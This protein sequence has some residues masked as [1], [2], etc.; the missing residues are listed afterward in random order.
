MNQWNSIPY[1]GKSLIDICKFSIQHSLDCDKLLNM[2]N[3]SGL[4]SLLKQEEGKGVIDWFIRSYKDGTCSI[5]RFFKVISDSWE[6]GLNFNDVT[7]YAMKFAS[8]II[9]PGNEE[10]LI[11]EMEATL[12]SNY[13]TSKIVINL[14]TKEYVIKY[15]T[16]ECEHLTVIN[17]LIVALEQSEEKLKWLL[18]II[19]DNGIYDSPW[20]LYTTLI[21]NN[22]K[23]RNSNSIIPVLSTLTRTYSLDIA[24]IVTR[25][26]NEGLVH[27]YHR[28]LSYNHNLIK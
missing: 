28:C 24:G 18:G 16:E 15:V 26:K 19:F 23:L 4:I 11:G 14:C 6:R 3:T 5:D 9:T 7:G 21:M 10:D 25:E 12:D 2:M 17:I 8:A 13:E 20:Q 22:L 27:D 1:T